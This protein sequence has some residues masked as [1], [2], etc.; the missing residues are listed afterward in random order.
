MKKILCVCFSATYQRTVV[1]DSLKTGGVNRANHYGLFASGKAVNSARVLEQLEKGCERTV[2]PLGVNSAEFIELAQAD[3]IQL[4]W[5]DVPWKIRECWTLLDNSNHT[6]TELI[7]DEKVQQQSAV[8][9]PVEGLEIPANLDVKILK[10][11]TQQLD[12]CDALLLAG[13]RQ[14]IWPQDIY[15]AIC[16]IALDIGKIVLADFI[17]NDLNMALKTAV[18]S[19]IKINDEEFSK[20]FGM[21]ATKENISLKSSEY[22]NI[23]VITR[24]TDST[25]AADNG[26]FYEC[27]V[28][29]VQAVN[30]IACGD[31]FNAGFLYEYL[32]SGNMDAALQKGTWC[33][34]QNALSEVPGSI[35]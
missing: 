1:F 3:G 28:P 20:T 13:S 10:L 23:I 35:L 18:P 6:T 16:G 32:K 12:E 4:S 11:I 15:P 29:K 24:G 9:E 22:H 31:S 27:L 34:V 8:P 7:A 25:I 5:I 33:A 26:Q 21:P 19:I 2:C 17:G 30:T 14:G